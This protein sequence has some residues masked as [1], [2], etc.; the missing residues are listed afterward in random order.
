VSS[1]HRRLTALG[2]LAA[3]ALSAYWVRSR[4]STGEAPMR[5]AE[6][7]PA[8]REVA[9]GSWVVSRKARDDY[10]KDPERLN[11]DLHLEPVLGGTDKVT[12]LVIAHLEPSSPIHGAG[13]R[14][15]DRVLNVNGFPVETLGRAVNL[16]HEIR[17]S[18][19]LTFRVGRGNETLDYEVVFE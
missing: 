3:V 11:R 2:I 18:E 7:G 8:A 9:K 15:G 10:L 19:R 12:E 17:G 16:I 1:S 14:Q 4:D 6:L 5:K 13:L